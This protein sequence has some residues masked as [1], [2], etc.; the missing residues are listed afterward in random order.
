MYAITFLNAN[1]FAV[2]GSYVILHFLLQVPNWA[3]PLGLWL[4][5]NALIAIF[6]IHIIRKHQAIIARNEFSIWTTE[7]NFCRGFLDGQFYSDAYSHYGQKADRRYVSPLHK[8]VYIYEFINVFATI[9]ALIALI[10]WKLKKKRIAYIAL[11][12]LAVF[13]IPSI[14]YMVTMFTEDHPPPNVYDAE[15]IILM[16]ISTLWAI[17]PLIIGVWAVIQIFYR[18]PPYLRSEP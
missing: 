4:W 18:L 17:I 13:A 12:T 11:S 10:A 8:H 14:I 9:P 3:A 5:F 7:Y 15:C 2:L 6:E 1:I 16:L